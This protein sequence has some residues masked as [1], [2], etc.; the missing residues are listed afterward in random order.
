MQTLKYFLPSQHNY[1]IEYL[2]VLIGSLLQDFGP[3]IDVITLRR[4]SCNLPQEY[5][6]HAQTP[7]VVTHE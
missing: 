1:R 3:T 4:S 5:D 7:R 2:S 6:R